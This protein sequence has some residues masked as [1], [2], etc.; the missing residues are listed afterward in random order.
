LLLA[1]ALVSTFVL[2]ACGDDD[3]GNGSTADQAATTA[4]TV[5]GA[6]AG[7]QLLSSAIRFDAQE[8][9]VTAHARH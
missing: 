5:P 7:A 9:T 3:D 8:M 2:A 1:L 4:E 6:P